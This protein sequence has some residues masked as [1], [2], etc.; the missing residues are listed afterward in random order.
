MLLVKNSAGEIIEEK[1]IKPGGYS[2]IMETWLEIGA[3]DDD[4]F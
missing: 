3:I 2:I 1:K 4:Y